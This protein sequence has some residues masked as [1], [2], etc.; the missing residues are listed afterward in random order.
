[1]TEREY[2]KH[3]F[4]FHEV[5]VDEGE[6]GTFTGYASVFDKLIPV[7][8]EKVDKGA[9]TRT[10]SKSGG[11]VPILWNHDSDKQIGWGIS[12]EE[13]N[14]G[15]KVTAR[16]AI[17]T[18][19]GR[20]VHELMKL[21][22]ETGSKLGLSIGFRP[23]EQEMKQEG[24]NMVRHLKE[25][26]LIEYSPTAFPAQPLAKIKSVRND[27][28]DNPDDEESASLLLAELDSDSLIDSV[29]L[30]SIRIKL[31]NLNYKIGGRT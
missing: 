1:M 22:V 29:D 11:K 21:G 26:Q 4:D 30:H 13:D 23:I 9:F 8:N 25:V 5:R 28:D 27:A 19:H 24:K 6:P 17:N 2:I 14:R 7:F 31:D 12:A 16:I 20:D 18:T 10:L 15:L 3:T